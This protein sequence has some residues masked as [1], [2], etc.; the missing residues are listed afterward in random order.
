[1]SDRTYHARQLRRD[2]TEAER[3]LW[4]L[5]RNRQLGGHKFRRQ[6]PI[7]PFFVDF[8]CMERRLVIEVDGS[9]HRQQAQYDDERTQALEFEGFR[10]Q[11]FWNSEILTD[12]ESVA[13]SILMELEGGSAEGPSPSPS[14]RGDPNPRLPLFLF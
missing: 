3:V 7:G 6:T 2:S 8:V 9:K 11:R 4:Q 12:L 13:D 14:G 1:M 5:L 10:V